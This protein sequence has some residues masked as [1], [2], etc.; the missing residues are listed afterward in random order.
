MVEEQVQKVRNCFI[1]LH[2]FSSLVRIMIKRNKKSLIYTVAVN[3]EL[4]DSEYT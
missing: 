4:H 1:S 3:W 2:Y